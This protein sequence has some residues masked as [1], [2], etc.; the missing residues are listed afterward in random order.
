VNAQ[1]ITEAVGIHVGVAGCLDARDSR[2][3]AR[4]AAHAVATINPN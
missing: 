3:A 4:Y 1:P 2:A